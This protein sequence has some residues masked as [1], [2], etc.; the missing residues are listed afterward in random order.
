MKNSKKEKKKGHGKRD[1]K[2]WKENIWILEGMEKR[3]E[4]SVGN[5]T[6]GTALVCFS[7]RFIL[8]IV[9]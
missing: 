5:I 7:L 8:G 9:A 2:F 6:C 1:A 4:K 3:T